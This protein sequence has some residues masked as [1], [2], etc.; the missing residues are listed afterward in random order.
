MLASQLRLYDE[1]QNIVDHYTKSFIPYVTNHLINFYPLYN[2][3]L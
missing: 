1:I 3:A 2:V